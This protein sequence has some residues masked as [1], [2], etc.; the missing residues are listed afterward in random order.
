M[1]YSAGSWL[2]ISAF[3]HLAAM[4]YIRL[5]WCYNSFSTLNFFDLVGISMQFVQ[6][7]MLYDEI[8]IIGIPCAM[9]FDCTFR[10]GNWFD[11][12]WS[13]TF[14][15]LQLF[16]AKCIHVP[17]WIFVSKSIWWNFTF[18]CL[19]RWLT[20]YLSRHRCNWLLFGSS[21]TGIIYKIESIAWIF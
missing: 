14:P 18:L 10:L 5:C 16:Y 9:L 4:L 12:P 6:Y 17:T 15:Y 2:T 21:P 20:I 7:L 11:W 13:C 8:G 19:F 1:K 3:A